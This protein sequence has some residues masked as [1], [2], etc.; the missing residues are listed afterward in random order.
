MADFNS[1]MAINDVV[2]NIFASP[3]KAVAFSLSVASLIYL[4]IKGV[5]SIY[6]GKQKTYLYP[7]GPPRDPLIGAIRSF[8]KDHFHERLVEWAGTYGMI[9]SQ[10]QT[11][12][13][14]LY[15]KV[16]LFMRLSQG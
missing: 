1:T 5:H 9:V 8:P 6:S 10:Y 14:P 12:N 7:P 2:S 13:L 4:A 16:I 15:L 11:L 3:F